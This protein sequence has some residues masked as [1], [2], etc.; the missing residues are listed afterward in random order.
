M[1]KVF[2]RASLL[3]YW[4]FPPLWQSIKEQQTDLQTCKAEIYEKK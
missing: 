3:A 2:K 1:L 4:M